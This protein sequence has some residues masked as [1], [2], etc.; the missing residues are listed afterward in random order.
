M[1][2]ELDRDGVTGALTGSANVGGAK[3]SRSLVAAWF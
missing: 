1:E 3:C 2:L